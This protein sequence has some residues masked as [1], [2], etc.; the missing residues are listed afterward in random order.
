MRCYRAMNT[1]GVIH[2][3]RVLF[4]WKERGVVKP[5]LEGTTVPDV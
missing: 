3:E 1:L 4:I 5:L 2:T